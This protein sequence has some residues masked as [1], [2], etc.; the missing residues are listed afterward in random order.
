MSLQ[1]QREP[2]RPGHLGGV[3]KKL[4]DKEER[5]R[6]LTDREEIGES[7]M[8]PLQLHRFPISG[9]VLSSQLKINTQVKEVLLDVCLFIM[10]IYVKPWLHFIL[11][12][13]APYKDL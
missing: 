10:T 8:F 3:D 2:G 13:K 1:R 9:D 7:K 12:V 4:V 11:A 5:T 6:L